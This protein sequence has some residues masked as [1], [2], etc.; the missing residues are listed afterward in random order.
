[1]TSFFRTFFLLSLP[2]F[3]LTGCRDGKAP[4]ANSTGK[5]NQVTVAVLKGQGFPTAWEANLS[6]WSARTGAQPQL[7]EV[8]QFT[9]DN[10][11]DW[12]LAFIPFTLFPELTAQEK[13]SPIPKT[14]LSEN[15]LDWPRLFQGLREKGA[16][17]YLGP[18]ILPVSAPT[19]VLYYRADLLE[20]A[21]LSPPVTWEDYAQ[22]LT[23]LPRWAPG[24]KAVEPWGPEFR[25]TMFLARAACYGKHPDH[26]T[27]L[28]DTETG[29]PLIASPA[30]QRTWK[31]IQEQLPK[32][33]PDVTKMTPADCRQAILTGQAALAITQEF[34]QTTDSKPASPV[35]RDEKIQLGFARLPGTRETYNPTLRA[36]EK[37]K[38]QNGHRVTLAGYAGLCA[39]VSAKTDE[40]LRPVAWSLATTLTLDEN[41]LMPSGTLSA[42]RETDLGRGDQ[43]VGPELT[44]QERGGYLDVVAKSLRDRQFT[45]E[46]PVPQRHKFLAALNKHLTTGLADLKVSPEQLVKQIETD[47]QQ[48]V[49]EIG[50]NKVRDCCR[51]PLGLRPLGDR[52]LLTK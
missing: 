30:F 7:Q 15:Q 10:P 34:S 48:L 43:L 21:K 35:K 23:D 6:E 39:V 27:F 8:D 2:L 25:A 14:S 11:A 37:S 38:E 36:W 33:A 45:L 46:M 26:T 12:N 18:T 17:T 16:E 51:I 5:T 19:L 47:W 22:L 28:F 52:K 32:L 50:P 42:T 31:N 29:A 44:A 1:M 9:A 49:I 20:K 13:I 40:T 24:L 4:S 3:A 41:A